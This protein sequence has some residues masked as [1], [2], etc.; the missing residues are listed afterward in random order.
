MKTQ[1]DAPEMLKQ[2]AGSMNLSVPEFER[3]MKEDHGLVPP[4]ELD[5][6]EGDYYEPPKREMSV[7]ALT[8]DAARK[9]AD[10]RRKLLL[11]PDLSRFEAEEIANQIAQCVSGYGEVD[12]RLGELDIPKKYESATHSEAARL[13]YNS[14]I[15]VRQDKAMTMHQADSL[16][17]MASTLGLMNGGKFASG[18]IDLIAYKEEIER[19]MDELVASS[20]AREKR[21]AQFVIMAQQAAE[22][23]MFKATCAPTAEA[24]AMVMEKATKIMGTT[25]KM[26][27][28]LDEMTTPKAG[29]IVDHVDDR[30]ITQQTKKL[31]EPNTGGAS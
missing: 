1:Q 7:V 3:M 16:N 31:S 23:L 26:L 19:Q 4:V 13:E 18:P 10:R 11:D 6:D 21:V 27:K 5:D 28:E 20:T 22:K 17:S 24:T 29:R 8:P 25:T 14:L 12:Q 15:Q 9:E 30:Q 2:M